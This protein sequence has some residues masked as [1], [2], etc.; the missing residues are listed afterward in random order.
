MNC[1]DVSPYRIYFVVCLN[2]WSHINPLTYWTSKT[3]LLHSL[4]A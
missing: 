1:R 2:V 4:I 3:I